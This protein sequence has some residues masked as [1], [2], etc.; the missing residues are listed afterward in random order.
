MGNGGKVDLGE[1]GGNGWGR[2]RRNYSQ[3][4]IYEKKLEKH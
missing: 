3:D 2:R 4:K 1:K